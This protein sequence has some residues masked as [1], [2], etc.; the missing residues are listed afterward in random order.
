VQ[1]QR[2][3]P[4]AKVE[5]LRKRDNEWFAALRSNAAR[6]V[7]DNFDRLVDPDPDIPN[8]LNDR[9]ADN[10]RP[11]LAI[12]DL[13]GGEWP[14]LARQAGLTL[15]GEAHDRA[16][17][18]ELLKDIRLAFGDDEVIR[19]TDLVAKLSA[20]P[21]RPWAD[22]KHGRSLTQRQLASL[23]APFHVISTTVHPPSLPHGKGYRRADFEEAWKA[24]CPGQ[25]HASPP[26]G[27]SETCKRASA[28][29]MG[30][31]HDFRSV[32][33]DIP[34]GSKNGN[35]SYGHAGLH[36]CTDPK[37]ENG[38]KGQIDQE[39]TSS[40][41]RRCDHCG[42]QFGGMSP[43]DWPPDRPTRT[44]W[45]HERCKAPWY[46]SGGLPEGVR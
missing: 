25:N 36:A 44:I 43:W 27:T 17:G 14:Q 38:A 23:L 35:L 18:V 42:S 33:E 37:P 45:L 19:S 8:A 20:D 15:S 11:L 16:I 32:R 10:W 46:D 1:L 12:A 9:A 40:Y 34:H 26:S 30:A 31:T 6:W 4:G 13:A 5:R 39:K 29:E 3:P 22:W 28:D 24:Y 2:K 41:D 7:A 21:E